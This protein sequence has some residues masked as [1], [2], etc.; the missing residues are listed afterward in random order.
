MTTPKDDAG[1]P[2]PEQDAEDTSLANQ[3]LGTTAGAGPESEDPPGG[4]ELN[5]DQAG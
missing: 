2:G 4:G 1:V 3:L 5:K